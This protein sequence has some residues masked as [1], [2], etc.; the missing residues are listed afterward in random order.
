MLEDLADFELDRHPVG[1]RSGV[2]LT[3][4]YRLLRPEASDLV[5]AELSAH[6]RLRLSSL[7][8]SMIDS[9]T[10]DGRSMV[11]AYMRARYSP[12]IP[13]VSSWAPEKIA[14]REA[15]KGNPGT[16]VHWRTKRPRT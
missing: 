7:G 14:I 6:A 13:R 11:R 2:G 8:R 12:M 16:L 5:L 15:R 9:T 3:V 4:F 10:Y 1:P